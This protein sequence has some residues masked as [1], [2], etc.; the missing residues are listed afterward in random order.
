MALNVFCRQQKENSVSSKQGDNM[1]M[2]A[3]CGFLAFIY[4]VILLFF[5]KFSDLSLYALRFIEKHQ[6]SSW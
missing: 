6:N 2:G 1:F 3:I 4:F 5:T